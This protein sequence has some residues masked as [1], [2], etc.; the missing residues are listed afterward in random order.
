M[1]P[2]C[3]YVFRVAQYAHPAQGL[4]IATESHLLGGKVQ[5]LI[6]DAVQSLGK[7]MGNPAK[8]PYVIRWQSF[9]TAAEIGKRFH[10]LRIDPSVLPITPEVLAAVDGEPPSV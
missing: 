8:N 6:H 1:R 4:Q 7:D 5:T 3:S 2:K 10:A 9:P